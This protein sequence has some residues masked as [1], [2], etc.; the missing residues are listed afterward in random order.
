VALHTPAN[1]AAFKDLLEGNGDPLNDGDVIELTVATNYDMWNSSTSSG[2]LL[3]NK[4]TAAN[5]IKIQSA[6]YDNWGKHRYSRI[7]PPERT[8]MASIRTVGA[9]VP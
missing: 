4:G 7:T 6:G 1:A 2:V 5:P 3:P 9:S 8:N